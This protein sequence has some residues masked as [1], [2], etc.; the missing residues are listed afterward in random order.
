MEGMNHCTKEKDGITKKGGRM[1]YSKK[2]KWYKKDDVEAIFF[3][4]A[5]P[6]RSL[7]EVCELSSRRQNS[8]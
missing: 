8:S 2:R 4:P 1:K 3:V 5:T 7:A 6:I